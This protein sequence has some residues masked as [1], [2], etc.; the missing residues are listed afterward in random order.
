VADLALL[1]AG[2]VNVPV[3]A[4][5]PPSQ[6]EYILRDSGARAIFVS[7]A[8]LAKI[9]EIRATPRLEH[10]VAFDAD[11]AGD[12]VVAFDAMLERGRLSAAQTDYA[13]MVGE[14]A[15]TNGRASSIR[16]HHRSPGAF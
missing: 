14:I 1:S 16:R 11:A 4:T 3:Y 6:I 13:A 12:G 15:A 7:R 10:M 9:G 5:L 2:Y 8:Q